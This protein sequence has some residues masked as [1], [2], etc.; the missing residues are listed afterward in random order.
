MKKRLAAVLI[1]LVLAGCRE[2]NPDL[3]IAQKTGD[4]MSSVNDTGSKI[5]QD[6]KGAKIVTGVP[7]TVD[8]RNEPPIQDAKDKPGAV[9]V[10]M[11]Y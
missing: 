10:K 6:I 1:V 9:A 5:V 8:D 3:R 2:S 7:A 11:E 4:S